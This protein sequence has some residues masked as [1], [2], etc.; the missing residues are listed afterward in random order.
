MAT[1]DETKTDAGSGDAPKYKVIGTRPIR[2]DGAD[3][4]TGRALYG[5]DIK[6]KGMIYGAIHRSPHA[7]AVIKSVDISKAEALPGVRAV[8]TSADM[9]EP[10]D[11]IAE[12]GEGAVNLNHLSSNNLARTKV[13]Y[14]GHPIAAVAADNIHIAQEAASLIEVEYEVLP[15][16]MDVLKAMEDDAPVLNPDVHTEEAVSGEMGDKPSNIAKHL[17]Y[18]KGDIAKGFAD[19]KYVVEKEFRTATVHQGYIEPH[20]ATSLW[21][22]DGQITVWTSTQ[23]TFSVRQ[24]VAELLDVPLARVKVVPMEI[25]GGFG[26]KISVYLAPVA[27]VLS[28]KSGAP[29]QLVMDRADVLQ[30]TG[31][32]PGSYIKV[33]M[34]AD[35]DGRITAAEAWMAYEAGGYPGSPIGAGCMCVFSCYDVPNGR[36]EGYD[37]CVNKPRT[38]AYRAPGATNAA[39][40]TETV[41]D[42]LCEQLGMAPIDFRLLNASKEGTRRVDG[43]TYP[44]IG[45]V[46]TLEAIK[47]SEHF[48]SALEGDNKGRGIACGFWF[49]AGLKSAVTATVNSDG[50]VGLLEGST[51]IGGS[52]TAIAMQFA[53]TLGIAA[54]DIKPAVVDTDSVGYT[55]VTGGS[56]VTYATGWAAYEAGKDLQRQIVSRA[57]ELWEVDPSA[58]SYDDGCVVG[59]DKRVPFKEIAIELSLTGEPLVGRGVSNHNEPGGAFGAHVVDVE[60]DPDTG[61]VDV[62]RYT[63][64]QDCGTAI[65]PA[66]VEGQIQGGAVQGIGWGLNEEYW[67]D[68]EGSMRNANFLDY[69]IPTCYDLPMIETIIVEVPNP[70]HPFGVRGVGEVPIVPPP[71]AL[72]A[73]IHEAVD[74]RMYELPM[75]PPRVLHELLQK[76]S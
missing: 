68:T 19:A 41:V 8:A 7:H 70:G 51:D 40:A 18:E 54:E 1:I 62:L 21:N 28:R 22:N 72:G 56:R 64:A 16:V 61:K 46:E 74:V 44:R 49:N 58:V 38:N 55:D 25:G 69:R 66:Y 34:G 33:K 60:V 63:A 13:L 57:A 11:K 3:K 43:V 52:R 75:S 67:Y 37:V 30:A 9:P 50:S 26:G 17:V 73:A 14:K 35:A 10:G 2:H 59:P 15:P 5:A 29:V 23:G 76:Q 53:E 39:F 24:Q 31:P 20:V 32:T 6:V 27:A 47:N 4:V 36:V 45:L 71:A 65:H 42:E 12:L 48:N